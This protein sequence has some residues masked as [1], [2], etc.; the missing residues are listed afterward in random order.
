MNLMI[1]TSLLPNIF[2]D[3]LLVTVLTYRVGEIST[4]PEF[5]TPELLLDLRMN[6]ENLFGGNAFNDLNDGLW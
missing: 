2:F 5:S 4:R 3:H 1:G 6:M